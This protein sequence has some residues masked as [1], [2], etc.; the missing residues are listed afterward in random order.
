MNIMT[1]EVLSETPKLVSSTVKLL[2]NNMRE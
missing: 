1:P 2:V